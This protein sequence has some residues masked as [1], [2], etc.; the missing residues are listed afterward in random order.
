GVVLDEPI[1]R[2]LYAG[3]VTDTGSFRRARAATHR[4]AAR[5]LE[6]GVDPEATIGPFDSHPFSW[7]T[8]LSS[9]LGAAQL[10]PDAA[11]G[12]GLV[13]ATVPLAVGAKARNEE[14]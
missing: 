5:L 14:I 2:C 4:M 10:E 1:A 3:L 8:M 6:A 9:V 11:Q 12:L 13:F 7:M